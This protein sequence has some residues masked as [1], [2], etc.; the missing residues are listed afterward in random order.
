MDGVDVSPRHLRSIIPVGSKAGS[1]RNRRLALICD[2]SA[3]PNGFA[4]HRCAARPPAPVW[5]RSRK[6]FSLKEELA[7]A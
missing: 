5:M 1:V 4:L 6:S 3:Q 2:V 7:L